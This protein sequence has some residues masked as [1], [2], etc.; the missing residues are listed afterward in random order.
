M[1]AER[2]LSINGANVE[3]LNFAISRIMLT[4]KEAHV[5][6]DGRALSQPCDAKMWAANLLLQGSLNF[7]PTCRLKSPRSL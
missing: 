5:A 2:F 6:I 7:V 4:L 3:T 1:L